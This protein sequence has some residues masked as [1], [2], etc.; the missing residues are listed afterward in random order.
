MSDTNEST[1]RRP[2]TIE[3]SATEV[4]SAE[5]PKAGEAESAAPGPDDKSDGSNASAP[6]SLGARVKSQ[7]AGAALGAAVM[8]ALVAALWFTGLIPAR[9]ATRRQSAAANTSATS[10]RLS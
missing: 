1:G 8:A 10:S 3:L 5:Q 6:A 2:P 9:E 7:I 4:G